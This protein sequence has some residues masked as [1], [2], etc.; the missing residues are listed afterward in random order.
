MATLRSSCSAREITSRARF[1][2][3]RKGSE[4]E[5]GERKVRWCC[6]IWQ[7]AEST[8]TQRRLALQLLGLG[9]LR[10]M[11]RQITEEVAEGSRILG[12]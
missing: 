4:V 9:D 1:R 7:T 2:G 5:V 12:V 3:S 10:V 11:G 8:G 6:T